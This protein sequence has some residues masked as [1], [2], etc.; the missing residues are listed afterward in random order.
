MDYYTMNQ[1]SEQLGVAVGVVRRLCNTGLIP[2]V[3]RDR[4]GRRI[5]EPWQIELMAVL[6]LLKEAGFKKTD[7]K[8]FS[9]LYQQGNSSLPERKALLETRK[10]QL[11][12]DLEECQHGIDLLERQIEIIDQELE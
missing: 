6:L 2:R 1:V 9:K 12:Q 7:L 8:R 3:R 10:R 5:F 11:W 4:R